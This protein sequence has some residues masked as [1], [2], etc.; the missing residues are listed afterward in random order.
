MKPLSAVAPVITAV[1]M[2]SVLPS[3]FAND[4]N[5]SLVPQSDIGESHYIGVKNITLRY[6]ANSAVSQA[7]AKNNY[8][9]IRVPSFSI[10][11]TTSSDNPAVI[12]AITAF[13]RAL[14]DVKS[15]TQVS[16]IRLAFTAVVKPSDTSALIS[17]KV[18]AFPTIQKFVL[19][20]GSLEGLN[21][22]IVDLEWRAIKVTEPIMMNVTGYGVIDVNRPIGLFE[23]LYPDLAKD[24]EASPGAEI[25][26]SPILDFAR[27]DQNMDSWHFLFDPSGS[28]VETSSAF[29]QE[30]SARVVSVYSLGES[31][32]REGTFEAEEKDVDAT[33]LGVPVAIHSQ[34]AAPSGQI[35]IAGFSKVDVSQPAAEIASVTADAPA[36]ATTATGGFPI[37]VLLVFGGMMGAIAIFIL[38]KARK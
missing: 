3:A 19:S 13:N 37:Q 33:L 7:F 20:E 29:R 4:M 36:G 17:Y 35:Q 11:G 21:S 27:F 22:K 24:V 12:S 25:F 34:V 31:S 2:L 9:D 6:P 1:L 32:F 38:W 16:S 15:P 14:L 18:E 26:N 23:K 30:G 5:G 28:L 10:N 8:A